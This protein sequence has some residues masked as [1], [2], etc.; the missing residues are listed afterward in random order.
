M[1]KLS[2]GI[3]LFRRRPQGVEVLLTHRGG[4]FWVKKDDGAWSIPTGVVEDGEDLAAAARRE[5][6]EETGAAAAGE[7]MPL[8]PV[9]QSGGKIVVAFAAEGDFDPAALVSNVFA[10]EWPPRSGKMAEFPEID[11][12]EWFDLSRAEAKILEGQRAILAA[13]VARLGGTRAS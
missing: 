1:P 3:L 4:P 10:M 5:F 13:L 9:K 2:A 8:G 7:L 6:R 11:R 12:A